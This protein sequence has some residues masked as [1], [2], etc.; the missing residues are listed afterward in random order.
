MLHFGFHKESAVYMAQ[1]TDFFK[2]PVFYYIM[3][4][5]NAP[6]HYAS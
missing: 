6:N 2:A 5:L 1:Q 3:C 4:P